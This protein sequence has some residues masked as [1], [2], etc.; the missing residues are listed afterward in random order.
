M[1]EL[2]GAVIARRSWPKCECCNCAVVVIADT[3][4]A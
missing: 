4:V 2:W 3:K 1:A